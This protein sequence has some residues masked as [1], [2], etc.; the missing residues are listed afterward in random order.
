MA[1][2]L[3]D[4]SGKKA[5]VTGGTR[6]LGHG[7]AEGLLEAGVEVTIFGTSESVGKVAADFTERGYKALGI[8][9]DIGDREA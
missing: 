1:H 9:V 8:Q 3:F 7:M 5:I 2:D 4:I 6:G